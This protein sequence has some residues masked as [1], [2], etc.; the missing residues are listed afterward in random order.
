MHQSGRWVPHRK[1]ANNFDIFWELPP[2]EMEIWDGFNRTGNSAAW[3]NS[4]I[5]FYSDFL[6]GVVFDSVTLKKLGGV[7]ALVNR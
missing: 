3:K 6:S 5:H 7:E 1:N 4:S 2:P